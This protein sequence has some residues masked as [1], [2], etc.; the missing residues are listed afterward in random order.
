[1]QTRAKE[2]AVRYNSRSPRGAKRVDFLAL[3]A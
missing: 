2:W 3:F 1:M